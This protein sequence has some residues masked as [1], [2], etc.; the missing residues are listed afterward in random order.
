MVK[1][2]A[3]LVRISTGVVVVL[4]SMNVVFPTSYLIVGGAMRKKRVDERRVDKSRLDE[5]APDD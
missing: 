5:R 3:S 1:T 2:T 4:G